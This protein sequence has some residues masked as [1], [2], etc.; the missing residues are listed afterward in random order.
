M[1]G[2]SSFLFPYFGAAMIFNWLLGG[3]IDEVH[4]ELSDVALY[5]IGY[6]A[7]L[8]PLLSFVVGKRYSWILAGAFAL[9]WLLPG[10]VSW[11]WPNIF[12][13]FFKIVLP[14]NSLLPVP[15]GKNANYAVGA[16]IFGLTWPIWMI[17]SDWLKLGRRS[18]VTLDAFLALI[19]AVTI[20]V[21]VGRSD[22]VVDSHDQRIVAAFSVLEMQTSQANAI[23]N[24]HH[25]VIDGE[26]YEPS[27]DFCKWVR[28]TW[29]RSRL[30]VAE[31]QSIR[32][33]F[34]A[35]DFDTSIKITQIQ[36][37]KIRD[38]LTRYNLFFCRHDVPEV[39]CGLAD[40]I[41]RRMIDDASALQN[42]LI[43]EQIMGA[44][45]K[46]R[47]ALAGIVPDWQEVYSQRPNVITRL[48]LL[49][50]ILSSMKAAFAIRDI[51]RDDSGAPRK[52]VNVDQRVYDLE[53]SIG[54]IHSVLARFAPASLKG[55]HPIMARLLRRLGL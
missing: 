18:R 20:V 5:V 14:V 23:C 35:L 40:P 44:I 21:I 33:E 31:P 32:L 45:R 55:G 13:D 27:T 34:G 48:V 41:L 9:L 53:Q 46:E 49:F 15:V 4:V 25:V 30:K 11:K 28:S 7:V 42:A 8:I 43:P 12:S 54:H 1:S 16:F 3:L 29:L 19:S 22:I 6:F 26:T 2:L 24:R 37:E 51:F 36:P 38:E 17:V 39:N 47:E 50:S 52:K 10:I